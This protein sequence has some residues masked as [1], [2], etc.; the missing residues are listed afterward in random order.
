MQCAV[1]VAIRFLALGVVARKPWVVRLDVCVRPEPSG[2][3][4]GLSHFA[5]LEEANLFSGETGVRQ[6]VA[7]LALDILRGHRHDGE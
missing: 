5:E 7:A 4:P 2:S 1:L 3:H 6:R